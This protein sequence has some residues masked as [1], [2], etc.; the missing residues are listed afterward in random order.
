MNKIKLHT[1]DDFYRFV[2]R[3]FTSEIFFHVDQHYSIPV[4]RYEALVT[5]NEEHYIAFYD[6]EGHEDQSSFEACNKDIK[7]RFESYGLPIFS[8]TIITR[9]DVV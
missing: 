4:M 1:A 9:E 3:K 2:T 5:I 8:G 6:T 7:D